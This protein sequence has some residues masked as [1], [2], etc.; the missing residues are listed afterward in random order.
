[1]RVHVIMLLMYRVAYLPT[2][3]VFPG[4]SKFFMKSPGLPGRAPNLPGNTYRGLFEICLLILV[5]SCRFLVGSSLT[6]PPPPPKC[7]LDDMVLLGLRNKEN[8]F[9]DVSRFLYSGG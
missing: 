1:M 7:R 9:V 5:I 3:P 2:L 6:P 4:V 8:R